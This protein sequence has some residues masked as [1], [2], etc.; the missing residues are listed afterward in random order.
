MGSHMNVYKAILLSLLKV[1]QMLYWEVS[2]I[3]GAFIHNCNRG[4]FELSVMQRLPAIQGCTLRGVPLW[5]WLLQTSILLAAS[6]IHFCR[7]SFLTAKLFLH[8]SI[9]LFWESN[10][11]HMIQI[12]FLYNTA[13]VIMQVAKSLAGKNFVVVINEKVHKSCLT[14]GRVIISKISS[15]WLEQEF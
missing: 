4:F 7:H 10:V 8:E 3:E 14:R 1:V 9:S 2:T 5:S 15:D 13:C 11:S 6:F 12:L